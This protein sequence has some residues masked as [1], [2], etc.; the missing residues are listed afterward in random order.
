M[1]CHPSNLQLSKGQLIIGAYFFAMRS[2]EYW[3]VSGDRCTKTLTLGNL[4]FYLCCWIVPH[5]DPSLALT[6]NVS[7]IFEFQKWDNRDDTITQHQSN[8]NVLCP[9]HQW[10]TIVQWI[11]SYPGL[12][13]N[14]LT[15]TTLNRSRRW[16]ATIMSTKLL[17]KLWAVVT[18]ISPD[19]LGFMAAE[20][21]LHP[22]QSVATMVMYLN[23]IPI[24][25]S[26]L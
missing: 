10:A 4:H 21:G 17:K 6:D 1:F 8:S 18:A 22:I 25:W 15:N 9:V 2:C 13:S 23:C 11:W 14:M 12:F 16:V 3:K 5:D 20:I 19:V 26:C 24:L 7:I